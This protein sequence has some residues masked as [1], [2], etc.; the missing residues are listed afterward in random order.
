MG[1]IFVLE[2]SG[3]VV[4]CKLFVKLASINALR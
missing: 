1:C 4:S 3:V 2:F